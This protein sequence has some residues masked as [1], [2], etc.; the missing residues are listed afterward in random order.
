MIV[1]SGRRSPLDMDYYDDWDGFAVNRRHTYSPQSPTMDTLYWTDP[2]ASSSLSNVHNPVRMYPL[3]GDAS[4]FPS[5]TTGLYRRGS[6]PYR[7][8]V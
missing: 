8:S 5:E 6:S 2:I 3:S 4:T 1:D 7:W